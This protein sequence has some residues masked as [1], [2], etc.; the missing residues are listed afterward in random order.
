MLCPQ[1]CYKNSEFTHERKFFVPELDSHAAEAIVKSN[2]GVFT[3]IYGERTVNNIYLDS[4]RLESYH[5]NVRGSPQRAKAR[6]RWYGD[7]F[8]RAAGP[9]LELKIKDSGLRAKI[10]YPLKPFTLDRKFVFQALMDNVITKSGLPDWLV[11]ELKPLK[12][13]L[14]NTYSRKYF[15]SADKNYRVTIDRGMD[16]YRILQRD[17][18]FLGHKPAAGVVVELKYGQSADDGAGA[19]T[20]HF[21]FRLTKSSKYVSGVEALGIQSAST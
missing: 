19:I 7:L 21:P 8:G 10:A 18:L 9:S 6:I 14:L 15:L 17:N 12:P 16:Y 20:N 11:S 3:E 4:P 13:V 5:D 2:P 1:D